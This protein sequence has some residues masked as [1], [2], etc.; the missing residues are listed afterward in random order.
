M[1]LPWTPSNQ[2][3]ERC[4]GPMSVVAAHQEPVQFRRWAAPHPPFRL[5]PLIGFAFL[6]V[7]GRQWWCMQLHLNAAVQLTLLVSARE[8]CPVRHCCCNALGAWHCVCSAALM[9]PVDL[10][11][12]LAGAPKCQ[13]MGGSVEELCLPPPQPPPLSAHMLSDHQQVPLHV[14][15]RPQAAAT[16]SRPAGGRR[17]LQVKSCLFQANF[18]HILALKCKGLEG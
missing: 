5:Q 12:L 17:R 8:P 3:P 10:A 2:G 4:P 7:Q 18:E 11:P 15:P 14:A 1:P 13:R 6:L 16:A 9:S